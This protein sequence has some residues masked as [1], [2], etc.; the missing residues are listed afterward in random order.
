MDL[1]PRR[2]AG[3]VVAMRRVAALLSAALLLGGAVSPLAAETAID[4]ALWQA[5]GVTAVPPVRVSP[6]T[7]PDVGGR[8]RWSALFRSTRGSGLFIGAHARW[9]SGSSLTGPEQVRE[10]RGPEDS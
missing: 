4:T 6:L 7:L 5:A 10:V 1:V 3:Y 8:Q 9:P 2:S